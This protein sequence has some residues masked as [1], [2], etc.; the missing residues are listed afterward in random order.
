MKRKIIGTNKF[1]V[2]MYNGANVRGNSI[3][4]SKHFVYRQWGRIW[5][6]DSNGN[7][8]GNGKPFTDYGTMITF[9]NKIMQKQVRTNLKQKRTW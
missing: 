4:E 6:V 3:A 1:V 5:Q 8:I 7:E 9:I 2:R